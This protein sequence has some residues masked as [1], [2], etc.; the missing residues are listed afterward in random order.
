MSAQSHDFL[1]EIGTEELPPKALKSLSEAF[2]NGIEA[3]LK[4]AGLKHQG[5]KLFASPRRLAV[6]VTELDAAQADRQIEKRGP[7]VKAPEQAVAG[8]ARSCGV[9]VDQLETLDTDKGQYYLFRSE[10]AGQPAT[11]LLPEIVSQ[12]LSKLPIPKRM[13][14]GSSR[15]EFVRPVHWCL[16]LLGDEVVDAEI[17]GHKAGRQT[18]GHRF[19]YNQPI[20]VMAPSEYAGLLQDTGHVMPDFDERRAMIAK[21]VELTAANLGAKAV[22][23]PALLDEV[24]ALVEW[25]VALAGRFEERFL[26]VPAEAL[27]S[28]MKEHQKYFH[29][30]DNEG[31]IQ[32]Y[33][34]TLSNIISKDPQQVI[35]G[36]EKVIRPRLADAA[37]FFE[38]DKKQT[39]ESR[40]EKLKPI[41]F[42]AE[43]GTVYEK[44]QRV[45]A[46]A[47]VIADQIGGNSDWAA[48]AAQL[49]K[50]DLVTEMVLEF[51]DLQGLMGYYYALNDGE[52]TEVAEAINEQYLPKFAGDK[53]PQT[54]TGIALAL[55]DR[56]DTLVGLF[57]INQPP[58]GSKDPFALRRATIGTLRILVEHKLD[59]DLLELL[60]QAA[61]RFPS[62]PGREGLEQRVLEFMLERF[63]AWYAD[64]GV[65]AEVFL[66]VMALRPSKPLEFD[67]RV[68]AVN[69][70][71]T[72]AGADALAAA[73]KRVSN[74]LDKQDA[75]AANDVNEALLSEA[76]EQA[77]YADLSG[78]NSRIET[79]KAEADFK[80]ILEQLSTL[81]GS[82]DRFFDEVMV[83]AD[84]EAVRTNRIALL[85]QLRQRFLL[86]ADIS[87]L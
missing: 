64:E 78:L 61:D 10:Q 2:G 44:V 56:L 41:V 63:R 73:N 38:T 6:L 32:P 12:S 65:P 1:V 77:L 47:T 71:R 80:A 34:I 15:I 40:I 33:F 18:H 50:T 46:L 11:A 8:F 31:Q 49:A 17:L 55:A 48:R 75:G 57:G 14:W 86:V 13:R 84:D 76:A 36:N 29:V 59:L 21:Q 4:E 69:H 23:D 72:L 43:L 87:L 79:L 60:A 37:F 51:S 74:I 39:L 27:I 62:L 20:D 53:L 70:F 22:I 9:A 19:H 30:V 35:A 7:S 67:Q 24:T 58:T 52:P 42:Q 54:R 16:M 66:S 28:S 5:V 25:P 85:N 26:D 3:G 45:S 68:Q 82:V 83:M 81:Q